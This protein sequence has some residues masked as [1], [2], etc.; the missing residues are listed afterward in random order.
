[1]IL[2]LVCLIIATLFILAFSGSLTTLVQQPAFEPAG[3]RFDLRVHYGSHVHLIQAKTG[4]RTEAY[5]P[6]TLL[7]FN[8]TDEVLKRAYVG[9]C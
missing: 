4:H 7:S 2:S 8:C 1:M 5:I 3:H 9:E 6:V